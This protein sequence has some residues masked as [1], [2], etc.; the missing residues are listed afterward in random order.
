MNKPS[1]PASP[2]VRHRTAERWLVSDDLEVVV[3]NLSIW[4]GNLSCLLKASYC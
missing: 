2:L 4:K 1:L 3:E